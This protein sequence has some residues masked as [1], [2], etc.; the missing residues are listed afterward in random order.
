MNPTNSITTRIKGM[1]PGNPMKPV[2]IGKF[3]YHL[4]FH[5]MNDAYL[6]YKLF[7][8]KD[9][10]S[11]ITTTTRSN[12]FLVYDPSKDE[13]IN[14]AWKS[15]KYYEYAEC[16]SGYYGNKYFIFGNGKY[17]HNLPETIN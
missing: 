3:K 13:N 9:G 11:I 2:S 1:S 4:R 14:T 12:M 7:A 8:P 5:E 17:M 10:K 6:N 16:E 15:W